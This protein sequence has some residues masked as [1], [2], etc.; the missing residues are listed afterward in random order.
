MKRFTSDWHAD[1]YN[2]LKYDK[3]SVEYGGPFHSFTDMKNEII[4]RH[5][6][7][8]K[9]NDEVYLIG[10]IA[11]KMTTIEE[12][13]PKLNGIIYLVPGNH[14]KA[15]RLNNQLKDRYKTV[16]I[17]VL[18]R[19]VKITLSNNQEVVLSHLPYINHDP[20]YVDILPKDEGLPLIH[21]HVHLSWK[22]SDES[23]SRQINVGCMNNNYYPYSEDEII[24]L[25]K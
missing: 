19:I 13:A 15:W 22:V 12:F 3:R 4:K 9:E 24:G 10:D 1:H 7:V 20:R 8:V 17:T 25:L 6:E 16:G 23:K 11:F 5:N 14:D 2:I 18:D 21:G